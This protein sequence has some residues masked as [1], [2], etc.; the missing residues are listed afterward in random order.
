MARSR[1]S[2]GEGTI[3]FSRAQG[4]WV[5]EIV[6]P[7]GKKKRKRSKRQSIVREWLEKEKETVRRGVWVSG[8]SVTYGEFL[9]R[10]LNEVAGHSLRPATFIS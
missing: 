2:N 10:Y 8:E 4:L 7:D 9:D 6:L 3:Y 5:A 1:R